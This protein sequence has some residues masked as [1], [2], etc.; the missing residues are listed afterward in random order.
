MAAMETPLAFE[1]FLLPL[2][3]L[4][5]SIL[6]SG[7]LLDHEA[8]STTTAWIF[9]AHILLWNLMGPFAGPL[10]KELGFRKLCLIGAVMAS[11]SVLVC[12]F[13]SSTTYLL[14]F[15][16]FAGLFGGLTCKPC[17]LIIP[18]YFD[19]RRGM[20]NAILMAGMCTGQFVA[21]PCIR[22]LL[23]HYGFTGATI[24]VS[25]ILL[26]C[27]VGASFFHPVEWHLKPAAPSSIGKSAS[28]P[29]LHESVAKMKQS[30]E[31][32][33]L[34]DEREEEEEEEGAELILSG[35]QQQQQQQQTPLTPKAVLRARVNRRTS[36]SSNV[37]SIAISMV[38]L[39]SVA[40][41]PDDEKSFDK[42]EEK[43]AD[44]SG[45]EPSLVVRVV[46]SLI[47]DLGILKCHRA[48]II[49][50]GGLFLINGYLNFMM[51]FPF[52]VQAAGYSLEDAAWCVSITGACNFIARLAASVLSD[53]SWFNMQLMYVVG[54][55][56]IAASTGVFSFL[57]NLTLMKVTLAFWSLGIGINISLY[58][59]VMARVMGVHNMPAIFGTQSLVV[60]L[61]YVVIG[62]LIGY[63]RDVTGSYSVS[64]WL[65]SAEV[66][67][68][69]LLWC[70]MPA[71]IARDRKRDEMKEEAE[72]AN[73][74]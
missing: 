67:L 50:F 26:N 68:C 41:Q 32:R 52:A 7:F 56:I 17:Y 58:P 64:M 27:C 60:G 21:P 72:N 62:P 57:T 71:A 38:D 73:V 24:I 8:S 39:S 30:E 63:V 74:L 65:M 3:T 70:F 59:L 9:N 49:A 48:Q 25:A 10:T 55:V 54:A 4:C 31:T 47:N 69:V 40:H 20:A 66:W 43:V 44:P 23:R 1:K 34:I 61:G 28:A 16:S 46:R 33:S 12:A 37:S 2:L 45:G 14:V 11:I 5:F 53:Y 29:I 51:V 19:K 22:Y 15:F 18:L 35:K 6:F 36:E 13:S 42:L